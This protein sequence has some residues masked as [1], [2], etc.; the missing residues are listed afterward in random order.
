MV[1]HCLLFVFVDAADVVVAAH[2]LCCVKRFGVTMTSDCDSQLLR[3][4]LL[5]LK[6]IVNTEVMNYI[7]VLQQ[8]IC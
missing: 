1:A 6:Q 5:F 7:N 4:Q 2:L 3:G 8:T